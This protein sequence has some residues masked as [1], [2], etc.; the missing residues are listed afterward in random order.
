MESSKKEMGNCSL[1]TLSK[2]AGRSLP[3]A[4]IFSSL[5]IDSHAA[6]RKLMQFANPLWPAELS[7]DMSIKSQGLVLFWN[8]WLREG[9]VEAEMM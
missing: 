5:T 2:N 7:I 1:F 6:Q 4:V 9:L 3:T 8:N